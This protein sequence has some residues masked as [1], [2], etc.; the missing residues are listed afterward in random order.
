MTVDPEHLKQSA[1]AFEQVLRAHN[2]HHGPSYH[3][4]KEW[5]DRAFQQTYQMATAIQHIQGLADNPQT[6]PDW[7]DWHI[8]QI[9]ND[10]RQI[11]IWLTT[12][13]LRL[14]LIM[15][16][17]DGSDRRIDLI[18]IMPQS[19]ERNATLYTRLHASDDDILEVIM[20]LPN[21]LAEHVLLA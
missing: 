20:R 18:R 5:I 16:R 2:L 4:H 17:T 12:Y 1:I 11:L 3:R 7:P 9:S 10:S 14:A 15:T 21:V 19:V 13:D 8:E 6:W